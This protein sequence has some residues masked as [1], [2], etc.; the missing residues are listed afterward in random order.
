MKNLILCSVLVCFFSSCSTDSEINQSEPFSNADAKSINGLA[1]PM[2]SSNPFDYKGKIYYD[3]LSSYYQDHQIPNST[4]ELNNQ[5]KFISMKMGYGRFSHKNII[6]FNDSIVDFIMSDPDNMMITIV[7]NSLLASASKSSLANFLQGLLLKRELEFGVKYDYVVSYEDSIIENSNI[8]E[9]DK[10]T[11]LTVTSISRYS[12]YSASERKDRDWESSAGNKK[13]NP[14]FSPD[15][16]AFTSII[17]LL[18][19]IL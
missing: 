5:I 6:S 17:V 19:N 14:I 9:D 4:F 12:L 13:A 1:L 16:I 11:I 2:N 7:Q 8:G 18:K 3:E 15:E 10:D